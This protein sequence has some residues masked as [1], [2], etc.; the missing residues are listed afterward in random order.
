L[1]TTVAKR[2]R[3]DARRLSQT[4]RGELDWIVMKCLEK[5]RSRRYDSAGSLARDVERYLADE[6]VQACPPSKSYRLRKFARRN[7]TPL[8][9]GSA[10]A[11]AL[12]FGIGLT[13]WQFLRADTESARAKAATDLLQETLGSSEAERVLRS[14]ALA[15]HIQQAESLLSHS[16]AALSPEDARRLSM[17]ATIRT[18]EARRHIRQAIQEYE[19]MSKHD[20]SNLDRRLDAITGLI[21][22]LDACLAAPSLAHEVD[23][24]N[25]RLEAELPRL[26]VE[27]PDSNDCRWE[28]AMRYV[29]WA[30]ALHPYS[31]YESVKE[32]AF[33]KEIEILERMA[34]VEPNRY[35]AW[36]FLADAYNH[37]GSD[38]WES[39]RPKLA[40][41]A[42]LR[43]KEIYDEHPAEI[44]AERQTQPYG[45][46]SHYVR[47][48]YFLAHTHRE[49]EAAECI[50]KAADY[51]KNITDP[52]QLLTVLWAMTPLQLR[53]GDHAGYR[54]TCQ[55]LFEAP[56][57]EADD[58]TKARQIFAWI[59]GPN[60]LD[61][62]SLPV[63]RA[64]ELAAHN[65][66]G[67]RDLI[68]LDLGA[69][70][71]RNRQYE[72]A[73]EQLEASLA[74]Y[75]S[76]PAP[77][78]DPIDLQRLFLAM[79]KWQSGDKD[80]ARQLLAKTLPDI[81]SN[82]QSTSLGWNQRAA[83]EV[84]R[85]EAQALIEHKGAE[86]ALSVD[87]PSESLTADP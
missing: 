52:I 87:R 59:L 27:F 31:R 17:G 55:A 51:A 69:A 7:K 54:A 2:R 50:R 4:V 53:M 61:D 65:S 78:S 12:L 47:L 11:A 62:L 70:L 83:L 25:R 46:A 49:E 32:H 1:A 80:Q 76:D 63:K 48:A 57:A 39:G 3:T 26:L 34:L 66:L 73:A 14:G 84:L 28:A 18:E 33:R 16:R 8:A 85:R 13:T 75:P 5:D 72:G 9:A 22:V 29:Q 20:P 6:P 15:Y 86:E 64:E 79:T 36:L 44:A 37:L 77:G 43:A 82:L 74:A 45:I 56:I 41:A 10:I 58:L 19:G 24:L 67:Q 40:E 71:Y 35:L 42:F 30:Y 23:E 68:L 21:H 81:E 60:A 38:A